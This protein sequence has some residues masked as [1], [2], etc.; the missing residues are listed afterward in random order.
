MPR[1]QIYCYGC[2]ATVAVATTR[3]A[4][5]L[6]RAGWSLVKGETYCSQCGEA[7]APSQDA[8]AGASGEN[9]ASQSGGA[10]SSE[11]GPPQSDTVASSTA[12]APDRS[13][14]RFLGRGQRLGQRLIDTGVAASAL[15]KLRSSRLGRNR[16]DGAER[17]A[18]QLR[19]TGAALI[20]TLQ[21]PFRGT[22]V[23]VTSHSKVSAP[24]IVLFCIAA[25]LILVTLGSDSLIVRLP[26]VVCSFAAGLSWLRDLRNPA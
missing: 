5:D 20:T 2:S 1:V 3:S 14:T 24:T 7:H 9:A 15:A 26:G 19:P 11:A 12:D 16:Q 10:I 8:S 13:Q 17:P 23:P 6:S 4:D 22:P 18:A 25:V 21:L